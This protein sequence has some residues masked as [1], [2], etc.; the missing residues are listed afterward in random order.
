MS[1]KPPAALVFAASDPVCGA[2]IQ[3]DILTLSALGCQPLTVVTALTAQDT[4]G[5]HTL[6]PVSADFVRRQASSLIE[7]IPIAAIKIGLLGCADHA[8]IA[9]GVAMQLNV[10]LVL[11]PVLASGRGDMLA[12]DSLREALL[13]ALLPHTD[14]V[15]PNIPEAHALFPEMPPDAPLPQLA[16]R[17]IERGA[18]HVLITGAHASIP[19]VINTLYG[20]E[21]KIRA[22]HW[23]RLSN[24]YHGSGC[25][26]ASAVA[27]FLARG[28]SM[29]AAVYEAQCYV[30]QT[31]RHA[32]HPG[33]GQAIPN[34]LFALKDHL[35]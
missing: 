1:P 31:L 2:G 19:E 20:A 32:H 7:D 33:R 23:P 10:P 28:Y 24:S 18:R 15:T 6:L 8:R 27:A 13:D 17:M 5:V 21:G 16:Q 11:D 26:L 29:E 12:D 3:A 34:R 14:L 30:S 4:T 9:A 22:D 25:T 35:P